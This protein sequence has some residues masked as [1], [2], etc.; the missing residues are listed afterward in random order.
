M[1]TRHVFYSFHYD[2]DV[3]RVQQIRNIGALEGQPLVH[4]NEWEVIKR[5]G[6]RAIQNWIDSNM[7]G[8]SCLIVLVGEKTAGREWVNYEIKHAW[9]KGMG[10][11]GIYIHNIQ[12]PHTGF[13]RQGVNPFSRFVIDE[14]NPMNSAVTCYNPDPDNAYNDIAFNLESL[15]EKAIKIRENY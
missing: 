1:V 2:N 9:D 12:C 13:S 8:K 5:G 3:M 6:N 15:V 4:I 14:K 7:E 10:V 11:L